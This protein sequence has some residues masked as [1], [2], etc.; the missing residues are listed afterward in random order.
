MKKLIDNFEEY[1]GA[2]LFALMFFVLI[3]QIIFRQILNTPLIWSEELSTFLYVYVAMLG[4]VIGVKHAQ[5][6]A[7]DFIYSK[8]N[9]K[10]KKFVNIVLSCI[11]IAVFLFIIQIGIKVTI[12]KASL[13]ILTLGI[14][15]AF[16]YMALPICATMMLI[17]FIENILKKKKWF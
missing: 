10:N 13:N 11:I 4:I 14:S 5:H 3:C 9:D 15:S 16:M 2:T 17:R 8:F 1:L 12:N 6:V 7:I